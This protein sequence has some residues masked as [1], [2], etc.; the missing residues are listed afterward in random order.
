MTTTVGPAPDAE[1]GQPPA[2]VTRRNAALALFALSVGGFGIGLTEFVIAGLL[3]E[4]ATDLGVTISQA[5]HLVGAYALAVVPGALLITPFLM[6]RPPKYALAVLLAFFV[7]GNLLSAWAPTYEVMMA[8]RIVAALAHGGYFGIGAV[9]AS[10]LVPASKRASAVA[11]LFAGLTIANVLGVP[12]G[13]LVGQ[14]YGWRM[15]FWIISAL[16]LLA[17]AGLIALV[18]KTE[19]ERDQLPVAQQFKALARP[20]VLASLLTTALV[21]GGMFGVFTYIEPLL[22]EVTGYSAT[23][24]PW[25]LVIFGAGLFAGNILGGK[26]ADRNAD[27]AVLVLS[28]LLP[29][30]I[31]TLGAIAGMPVP[32]A[33]LLF[34][35]GLVGFATVPGLQARV[36]RHAQGAATLAS[37]TNIAAFNLGNTIGVSLA[38]AAIAAGYGLVSPTVV[39]AGLTVIGLTIIVVARIAARRRASSSARHINSAI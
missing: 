26:A 25:L 30:V 9:L 38:G 6:R 35:L 13:A 7:V 31:L 33:I 4:V 17:L 23:A 8:G 28:I 29:I 12:A 36:M 11:A 39:G 2:A 1:V 32:V 24:I 37:A 20:Q 5:G 21:F 22:R 18:P 19:P 3:T 14:Q 34:L 27:N 16:G 10:A 15:V